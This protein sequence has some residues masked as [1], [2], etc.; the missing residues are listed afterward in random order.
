ME[1]A[2][3]M[4]LPEAIELCKEWNQEPPQDERPQ[5]PLP[6][7]SAAGVAATFRPSSFAEARAEAQAMAQALRRR[8]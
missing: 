1:V 6:G 3:G 2:N 4:T 5:P 7:G 8:G